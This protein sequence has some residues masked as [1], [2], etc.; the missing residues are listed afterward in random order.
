MKSLT[1]FFKISLAASVLVAVGTSCSSPAPSGTPRADG[2]VRYTSH[3]SGSDYH[4]RTYEE[5]T[6]P[7][8][9]KILYI[10][11]KSLPYVSYSLMIKAGSSRDTAEDAGLSAFVADLLETGTAK[12]SAIELSDALGKIGVEF[13][14]SVSFDYTLLAASALNSD[15]E[16]LLSLFSEIV[17]QPAFSEAEVSRLR[18]QILAQ[19]E[20]RVDNPEAFSQRAWDQYLYG[21]HPY[22]L[23]ESGILK[24][25]R[26][27]KHKQIIQHYLKFYRPNNS[28]LSIVGQYT[29]EL[30]KKIEAVMGAW[31]KRDVPPL[32]FPKIPDISGV[33]LQ[34]VDKGGM[35]QA[36]VRM[37]EKGIAR[38]NPDFLTL[39]VANTILGG[40]FSS[41]L[42]DRVRKEL[43]LTYS[44]SSAFDAR[45][46]LGPFEISTFTKN[47][48]VAQVV[49]ETLKTLA[50]FRE[51]GVTSDEV[52]RAKGYMKGTFPV[53]IET[54]EKLAFNLMY[55]RLYGIPDTYLSNYLRDVDHI[56]VGMVNHAIQHYIDD[57]NIKVLVYG[58]AKEI[59]EQFKGKRAVEVKAASDYK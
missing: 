33:Q 19:I 58:N 48:S 40:A 35:V 38:S 29:P 47:Q 11:D 55:L 37:G 12:H 28:Y 21:S 5:K 17:M 23:P 56:S 34:V 10:E 3:E 31:Q 32:T 2:V 39:R 45:Q 57:K 36:Q 42:V 52:E 6:L 4:P 15:A 26:S 16:A 41:R 20:R 8:G 7:N 50:T 13:E 25:M 24:S 27:I 1:H 51:K 18:Q 9:L 53:A 43:G 14:S 44:I 22:G 54:A 30:Q 59:L 49:D 46:D